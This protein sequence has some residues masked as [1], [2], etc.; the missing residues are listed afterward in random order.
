[1]FVYISAPALLG[2]IEAHPMSVA[3]R[4]APPHLCNTTGC[5]NEG[6]F[7]LC[8]SVAFW[9]TKAPYSALS[10]TAVCTTASGTPRGV[11]KRGCSPYVSRSRFGVARAGYRVPPP[12]LARGRSNKL[13][14]VLIPQISLSVAADNA[15]PSSCV[16]A[17]R[18][19][20]IFLCCRTPGQPLTCNR[21]Q[22]PPPYPSLHTLFSHRTP[23]HHPHPPRR[24]DHGLLDAG[25]A[26]AGGR[27]P[28]GPR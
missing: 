13:C 16:G 9:W 12:A 6:V 24:Q 26:K 22:P 27:Q 17:R 3:L 10:R 2:T 8:E 1:M 15:P 7:T 5:G 21:Q 23:T 14:D 4:G 11:R 28:G 18:Q 25:P 19:E 20:Q